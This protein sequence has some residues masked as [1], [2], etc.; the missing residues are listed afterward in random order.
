MKRAQ[1]QLE[2]ELFEVLRKR[3]FREK[4]SISAVVREIL[5]KDMASSRHVPP[6]S[7]RQFRFVAAGK[8]KQK[9][10][11][12]VSERHDEALSVAFKK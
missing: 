12:P 4:R 3:A 8:S 10:L 7:I 2:E 11:K 6:T 5:K 9:D 1:I